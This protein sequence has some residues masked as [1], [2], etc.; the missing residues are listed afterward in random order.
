VVD[1]PVTVV[2][3]RKRLGARRAPGHGHEAGTFAFKAG[4]GLYGTFE[5]RT[6]DTLL[7]FGSNGRVYLGAGGLLPAWRGDG[8]PVTTPAGVGRPAPQLLVYFAGPASAQPAAVAARA[9]TALS[10]WS[11]TW[12]RARKPARPLSRATRARPCAALGV[13]GAQGKSRWRG[14]PAPWWLLPPMWPALPPAGAS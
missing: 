10:P 9:A 8:Q 6:V 14:T 3:S 1:E 4:D 13:S 11:R 5:C 2:V 12:F 7:V